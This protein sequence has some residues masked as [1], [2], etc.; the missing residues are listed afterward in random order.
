MHVEF[1]MNN[2]RRDMYCEFL[3]RTRILHSAILLNLLIH[4]KVYCFIFLKDKCIEK[5]EI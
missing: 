1:V 2:I 5:Q 4:S 3:I